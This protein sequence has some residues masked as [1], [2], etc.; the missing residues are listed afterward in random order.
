VLQAKWHACI[1]A[2]QAL[3]QLRLDS[4]ILL[5]TGSNNK[6]DDGDIPANLSYI[7]NIKFT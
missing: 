2:I 1:V 5:A 3:N 6:P 4:A 7:K